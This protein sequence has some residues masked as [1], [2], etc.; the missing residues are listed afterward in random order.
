MDIAARQS[1]AWSM[2]GASSSSDSAVT[3]GAD[4]ARTASASATRP[5]M[6]QASPAIPSAEA[7]TGRSSP[8]LAVSSARR[9]QS[10][11]DA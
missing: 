10:S 11:I 6:T 9:A 1:S 5:S 7:I 8:S 4:S 3:S 2:H